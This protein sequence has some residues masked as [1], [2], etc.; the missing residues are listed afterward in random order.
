MQGDEQS[1]EVKAGEGTTSEGGGE[2]RKT[3][4]LKMIIRG[5]PECHG[6]RERTEQL[7][8]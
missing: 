8:C 2:R 7:A 1:S 5:T 3:F 6:K 4:L